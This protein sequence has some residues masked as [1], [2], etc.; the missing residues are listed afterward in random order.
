MTARLGRSDRTSELVV[1]RDR[2]D[3]CCGECGSS[4]E[5]DSVADGRVRTEKEV[6]SRTQ[7]VF[8]R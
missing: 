1:E 3:D 2:R 6:N 7:I 8:K 4:R 5:V